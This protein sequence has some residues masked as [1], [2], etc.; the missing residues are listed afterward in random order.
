MAQ[1]WT[2]SLPALAIITGAVA[3]SGFGKQAGH[4]HFRHFFVLLFVVTP[5][6]VLMR[7]YGL[8]LVDTY[9]AA[10]PRHHN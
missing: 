7:V 8:L 5:Q 1:V 6:A 4:L 9:S 2:E 3:L 10:F